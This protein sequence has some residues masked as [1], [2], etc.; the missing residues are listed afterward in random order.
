MVGMRASFSSVA[1]SVEKS[2]TC[3]S[4]FPE[5][6]A[7]GWLVDA[8]GIEPSSCV[9]LNPSTQLCASQHSSETEQGHA[10]FE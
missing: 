3:E 8:L 1:L 6:C 2:V 10:G 5:C 4:I 9:W 7:F